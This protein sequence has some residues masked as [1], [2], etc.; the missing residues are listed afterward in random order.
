MD[1]RVS[2]IQAVAGV[3]FSGNVHANAK[4]LAE[5]FLLTFWKKIT[6][7]AFSK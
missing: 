5:K 2:R 4:P 3:A 7:L 1:M 6:K